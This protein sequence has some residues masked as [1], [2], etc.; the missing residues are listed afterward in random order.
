MAAEREW[1]VCI[2]GPAPTHVFREPAKLYQQEC[3]NAGK[4]PYLGWVK[5]IYLDEDERTALR[6]AEQPVRNFVDF[7]VSPTDS[8]A[9]KHARREA[10]FN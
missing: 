9:K 5:A 1:G 2:G 4:P 3:K 10:T 6:E 7:N 8:L